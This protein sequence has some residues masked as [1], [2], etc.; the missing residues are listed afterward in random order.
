MTELTVV[1][2]IVYGAETTDISE[3]VQQY[4]VYCHDVRNYA[5]DTIK[6]KRTHLNQIVEYLLAQ[7]LRDITSLNNYQID[8]YFADYSKTH[9]KQT[10]NAGRRILKTFLR[11][12]TD[13]KELRIRAVPE[14][15]KLVRVRDRTPKALDTLT[16]AR[17]IAACEIE[18]DGLIIAVF[19]E[20]GIRIGEL[21]ELRVM[22]VKWNKVHIRGKGEVDR[23][24]QITDTLAMALE[25]FLKR[26]KRSGLDFV[27]QNLQR[28]PQMKVKNVWTRVKREFKKFDVDMH[29]HQLRHTFA[30]DLLNQGCDLVTIQTLLGHKDITT[31]MNYLR[32]SDHHVRTAYEKSMPKSILQY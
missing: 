8:S 21:V 5:A 24:A 13:Y 25:A 27:F 23:Y 15:I 32:V 6:T 1:R 20:T 16:I 10:V 17:V 4:L 14:A 31:T 19:Y 18:Q 12:A 2:P 9:G 30:I 26:K 29:P 3:L 7:G 22:D 28:A 11:W